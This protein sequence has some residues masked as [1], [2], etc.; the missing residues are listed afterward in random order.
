M[1]TRGECSVFDLKSAFVARLDAGREAVDPW[2]VN[3]A[4]RD[5]E[6]ADAPGLGDSHYMIFSGH[7][8]EPG[9]PFAFLPVLPSVFEPAPSD[10]EF[11][12]NVGGFADVERNFTA[13]ADVAVGTGKPARFKLGPR[14][15]LT[16][17][18]GG[19]ELDVPKSPTQRL[20][21]G[22]KTWLGGVAPRGK[23]DPAVGDRPL[24]DGSATL[25]T[26]ETGWKYWET[27]S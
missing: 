7:G 14:V 3:G 23:M 2:G 16:D 4:V 13:L 27:S 8:G 24:G 25:P 10:T 17:A 9:V 18:V 6:G 1:T 20:E 11:H 12:L 5:T 26:T 22:G 19:E 15:I 21:P